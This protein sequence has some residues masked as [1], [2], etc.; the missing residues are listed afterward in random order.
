MLTESEVV[1]RNAG[2]EVKSDTG[3]GVQKV[4]DKKIKKVTKE[5]FSLSGMENEMNKAMTTMKVRRGGGMD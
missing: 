4:K 3:M 5:E 1:D 2:E